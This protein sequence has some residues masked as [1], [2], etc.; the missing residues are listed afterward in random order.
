MKELVVATKNQGKLREIR[1]LLADLDVQV[2]SL[3]DYPGAPDIVEDGDSFAA[4]ALIKARI[5]SAYTGKLT[6]G[7]DSG[8]EVEALENRPGIYS[9]R[10][11]GADAKDDDNNRKLLEDLSGVPEE[12]RGAR[13]RCCIALVE[14]DQVIAEVAG[15]CPGRI[16]TAARGSNGFGYDPYFLIPE[17]GKTFGE[18]DPAIKARISHRAAALKAL[19]EILCQMLKVSNT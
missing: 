2:T 5:V 6:M 18:L 10:Y 8:L 13:Y 19:R 15:Q 1:G 17:Y 7:E 4:N 9:A 12:K 11:A 16:T 3:A 14:D